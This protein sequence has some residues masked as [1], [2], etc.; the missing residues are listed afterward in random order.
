MAT[1]ITV[2]IVEADNEETPGY[3]EIWHGVLT[4]NR[5]EKMRGML[6]GMG[7]KEVEQ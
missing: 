5:A 1:V 7:L 2:T 6:A 3:P 4:G